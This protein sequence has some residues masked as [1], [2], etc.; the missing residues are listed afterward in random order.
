[1]KSIFKRII[2]VL[3]VIELGTGLSL[4]ADNTPKGK[5]IQV[6]GQGAVTAVPDEATIEVTV[7]EGG[8]SIDDLAAK[9]KAKTANV[10]DSLKSF[11]IADKDLQ[12]TQYGIEP[13]YQYANGKSE[14]VG[15]TVTNRLKVVLKDITQVGAVLGALSNDDTFQLDGPTF[16]FSDPAKLQLGALKAAV[17]NAWAKAAVLAE[18][19]N[20]QLG[21]VYSI[22]ESSVN[23]PVVRPM[24]MARMADAG[25]SAVPVQQGTDQVTAQVEVVYT[26]K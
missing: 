6:E 15:Y 19:A 1:M 9:V 14:R 20:A 23:M 26:L 11:D 4:A 17:D 13:Q 2:L 21:P 25:A 22:E 7:Q 3:A 24:M 18:A 5:T 10:L 12:T 8:A 16:G